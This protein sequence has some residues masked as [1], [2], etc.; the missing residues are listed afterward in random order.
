MATDSEAKSALH[1]ISFCSDAAASWAGRLNSERRSSG[2][3]T[4]GSSTAGER[5]LEVSATAAPTA[6]RP[7]YH[8]TRVAAANR[9]AAVYAAMRAIDGDAVWV[10]QGW[11]W[12]ALSKT[13]QGKQCVAIISSGDA[14]FVECQMTLCGP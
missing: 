9:A 3:P 4:P 6:A 14:G 10:Y 12:L 5:G 8:S 7:P 11:P 2:P 1:C 13:P